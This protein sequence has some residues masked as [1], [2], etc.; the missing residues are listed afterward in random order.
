MEQPNPFRALLYSR[1]FWLAT[2]AVV[3]TLVMHYY[4]VDPQVWAAI[5]ALIAVVI[6]GIAHEDA[7]EKRAG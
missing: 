2:F 3:Q 4:Q 7:A 6:A 5:D 1:K